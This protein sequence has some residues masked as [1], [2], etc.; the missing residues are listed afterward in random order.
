MNL[1]LVVCTKNRK[2]ELYQTTVSLE[3]QSEQPDSIVVVDDSKGSEELHNNIFHYYHPVPQSTG[4][5]QARNYALTKIPQGT[6][7]VLFLDDDVILDRDYIANIKRAFEEHPDAKGINGFIKTPYTQLPWYQKIALALAGLVIPHKVQASFW[8]QGIRNC[9]AMYPVFPPSRCVS[10]E[11]LSGCNMAYREVLFQWGYRFDE[12]LTGYCAGEDV[13][14]SRRLR[15]D[16][17]LLMMEPKA[18]LVHL[19]KG[20]TKIQADRR[21]A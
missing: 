3:M 12:M 17:H 9:Q 14:F 15:A 19:Q 4:L 7:I 11:W 13:R 8:S 2:N 21:T 20:Y 18:R 10:V 6:D 5:T 16:G 1:C